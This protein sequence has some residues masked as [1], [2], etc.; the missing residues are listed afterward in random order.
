[1]NIQKK[2]DKYLIEKKNP[3]KI[4]KKAKNKVEFA[5]SRKDLEKAVK[6]IKKNREHFTDKQVNSIRQEL[7]LMGGLVGKAEKMLRT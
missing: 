2:I 6:Y 3:G 5:M 4:Y 7:S 1:M